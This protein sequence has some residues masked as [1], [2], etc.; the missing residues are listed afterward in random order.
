MDA[1]SQKRTLDFIERKAK[2]GKPFFVANWP[3][4]ASFLPTE[5]KVSP[6]RSLL[7]DGLQG[8][9]DPFVGR[10]D[11]ETQGAGYRRKHTSGL[12]RR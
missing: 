4:M 11:G 1:E 7:Q 9:V 8:N 12:Q 6:G 10:G 2:E 5:E 3:L